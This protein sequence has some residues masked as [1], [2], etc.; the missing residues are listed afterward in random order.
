MFFFF[1]QRTKPENPGID[2]KNKAP[3]KQTKIKPKQEQ[4][5]KQKK[6]QF[7]KRTAQQEGF[8]TRR[9][10]PRRLPFFL[11]SS[12]F[13]HAQAARASAHT[14][15]QGGEQEREEMP[16]PGSQNGR[17]RPAKAETIHGLARAG[18]LAG[19]Q[20][21]LQ[22]NP[23]LINDRNPVVRARA[24]LPPLP[25]AS[26]SFNLVFFKEIPIF[27]LLLARFRLTLLAVWSGLE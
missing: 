24:L 7:L 18:D 11:V 27:C 21:K 19:V 14:L 3:K 16:V 23:A 5:Q 25:F 6:I 2:A 20:R 9:L 4:I 1:S 15:S 8:G 22:E 26:C 17:P 12:S 10:A 13:S